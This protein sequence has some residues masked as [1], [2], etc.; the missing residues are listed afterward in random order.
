MQKQFAGIQEAMRSSATG[1]LLEQ[2]QERLDAVRSR[3][4]GGREALIRELSDSQVRLLDLLMYSQGP[5]TA[6]SLVEE[7]DEGLEL[8]RVRHD[9]EVFAASGLLVAFSVRDSQTGR[10][11][12]MYRLP[13]D[14]DSMPAGVF[15]ESADTGE[16]DA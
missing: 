1:K 5:F 13:E 10:W 2:L 7:E 6:E 11:V 16:A 4:Q 12:A 9:L 8:T 3:V 14:R 15:A